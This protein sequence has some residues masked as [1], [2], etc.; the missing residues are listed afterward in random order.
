MKFIKRFPFLFI[1]ISLLSILFIY[2]NISTKNKNLGYV[3]VYNWYGMIPMDVIGDFEKET[4]IKVRYDYYDSNEILEAKLFASN[5][6][7]DVVFPSAMPYIPRQIEAGAYREIKK[8]LIPN[9]KYLDKNLLKKVEIAD[10]SNKFSIPL[11][12]GTFGVIVDVDSVKKIIGNIPDD[13]FNMIFDPKIMEKL[14]KGGVTFLEESADVYPLTYLFLNLKLSDSS[15]ESLDKATKYL[16]KLRPFITRFSG[17]GVID[18]TVRGE[19]ILAMSW[20]GEGFRACENARSVGKNLSF[21]TPKNNPLIWLD[22]IAI[23]SGA[24]NVESA[25]KFINFILRPDICARLS[26]YSK[27]ATTNRKSWSM[28]DKSIMGK[29]EIFPNDNIIEKSF[30]AYPRSNDFYKKRNTLWTMVKFNL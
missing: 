29:S 16:K 8:E 18:E 13:P 20:S 15:H 12:W 21:F 6:G 9:V 4:G 11:Y 14:Y 26:N 2:N 3:N 30:M 19:S 23:P 7:Y 17:S 1:F 27:L 28:V 22:M 25:H 5:S 10:P 24:P